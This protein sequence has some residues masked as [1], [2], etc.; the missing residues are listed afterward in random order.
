MVTRRKRLHSDDGWGE[1]YL[2]RPAEAGRPMST[3]CGAEG[4]EELMTPGV[5]TP[6]FFGS[7]SV[8]NHACLRINFYIT[9][10]QFSVRVMRK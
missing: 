2:R 10:L 5:A 3:I 7:R 4:A 6:G 9:C 1:L 8:K